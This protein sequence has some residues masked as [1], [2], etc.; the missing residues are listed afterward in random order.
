MNISQKTFCARSLISIVLLVSTLWSVADADMLISPTRA[1]LDTK[2]RQ[3]ELVLRNTSEGSR[4]Y[5]LEWEDKR[6]VDDNGTYEMVGEGENWPSAAN[7]IRFSP[8]QI[9]V[10]PGENQTVRLSLRPPKDLEPGE[11]RSHL[12]LKVVAKDSEPSGVM[13][14][15]DPNREGIGFKL[16]MQM[17]F[18]IPIV[19]RHNVDPPEVAISDIKV[20]PREGS[21]QQMALAV[22]LSRSGV[23]S[24]YGEIV[25]E[26]QKDRNSPVERIGRKKG[27]YVF[28]ETDIKTVTVFLRDQ[29]IPPKSYI[30]V[31]YEGTE[32]YEGRV[33]DE[34]IFQSQ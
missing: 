9:T 3:A 34:K 12:L 14:M 20:Q 1:A 4:T 13:E 30:R 8:R 33:W 31:A 19:V 28:H 7:M 15:D 26:M 11:Y 27:V 6:V 29:R 5:R 21:D 22:E 32:E 23:A 24:S 17:S 2:D 25:V 16:F 10:G 18:S